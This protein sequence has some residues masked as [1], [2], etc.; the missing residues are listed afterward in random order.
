MSVFLNKERLQE[1]K[2][3]QWLPNKGGWGSFNHKAHVE[4]WGIMELYKYVFIAVVLT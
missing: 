1:Q 3:G 4:I 2:T